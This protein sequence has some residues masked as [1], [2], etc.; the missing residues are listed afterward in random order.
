M[1]G[2]HLEDALRALPRREGRSDWS[3]LESR[4]SA[5]KPMRAPRRR[6]FSR[7]LMLSSA[8]LALALGGAFLAWNQL[9]ERPETW[10]DAHRDATSSDPWSDP[11]LAAAVETSR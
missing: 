2:R 9:A 8:G 11:W 4:I 7:R 3:D 5:L 10:R 6:M 1:N